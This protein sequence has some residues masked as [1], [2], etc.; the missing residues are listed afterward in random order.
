MPKNEKADT[1]YIFLHRRIR[2]HWI[3]ADANRLKWWLDILMDCNHDD[4]KVLIG[5]KVYDCRRGQSLNSIPTWAKAWR[6]DVS[7]VKRF[8]KLLKAESMISTES[9][10]KTTLLTVSNY[11][12]Y[13]GQRP[14]KDLQLNLQKTTNNNTNTINSIRESSSE[15]NFTEE[16]NADWAKFQSWV[17]KH[18]PKLLQMKQPFTQKQ[19]LL[20]KQ[21]YHPDMIK[22]IL[23]GMQNKPDLLKKYESANLTFKRWAKIRGSSVESKTVEVKP[24]SGRI[25]DITHG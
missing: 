7:V 2:Q 10:K 22:D 14:A 8:F 3:W 11:D 16:E 5:S 24:G 18:T 23:E 15:E 20:I 19:A 12:S 21:N 1:G 13:N 9:V 6:V 4:K 25:K 17:K